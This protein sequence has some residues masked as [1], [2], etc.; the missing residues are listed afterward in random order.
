MLKK[1]I[2]FTDFDGNQR[3]EDFYFN[4]TKAELMKMNMSVSGG[5]PRTLNRIIAAQDNVELMK[6]FEKIILMSYGV[7]SDDGRRFMKSEE[8]SQDFAQTGAYDEL[9]MEL[10]TGGENVVSAFINGIL[11]SDIQK[12]IAKQGAEGIIKPVK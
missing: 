9:F 11:P 10:M 7:K 5:L 1:T 2:T 4:L 6:Y 3:T 12:E 8:I